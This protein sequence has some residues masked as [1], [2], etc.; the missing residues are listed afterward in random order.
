MFAFLANITVLAPPGGGGG[1]GGQNNA[2]GGV[3]MSFTFKFDIYLQNFYLHVFQE[4]MSERAQIVE[5]ESNTYVQKDRA[6]ALVDKLLAFSTES[7]RLKIQKNIQKK[8]I[9]FPE[10]ENNEVVDTDFLLDQFIDE[11]FECKKKIMR[12]YT[13]NFSKIF[14][15]DQGI[16]TMD[17][18]KNIVKDTYEASSQIEGQSYPRIINLTRA[19]LFALTSQ[20]NKFDI[21][22][23]DFV[24]SCSRYGLDC[25]FPF[26]R[27]GGNS[28]VKRPATDL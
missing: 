5:A 24:L 11:Y 8:M 26:I 1:G 20:K 14:D 16:F 25:P 3:D 9:H 28:I 12:S 27:L 4:L 10:N 19:F 17:S 13:K 21:A 15:E 22:S 23:R 6:L 18:F 2:N 7:G